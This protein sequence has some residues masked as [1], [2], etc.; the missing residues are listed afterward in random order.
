[1]HYVCTCRFCVLEND[2]N[3]NLEY[4]LELLDDVAVFT[5]IL[6]DCAK[7]YCIKKD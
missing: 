1:M 2:F 3:K 7:S 4:L 5:M 6:Q